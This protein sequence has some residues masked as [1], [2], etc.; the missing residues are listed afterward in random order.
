[1]FNKFQ[2]LRDEQ[3]DHGDAGGGAGDPLEKK[4][5]EQLD[6]MRKQREEIASKIS[7]IDGE[8]KKLSEDFAKATKDFE[9]LSSDVT[10]VITSMKALENKVAREQRA[11]YGSALDRITRDPELH[12]H[13][14]GILRGVAK[15]SCPN[16]TVKMNDDQVKAYEAHREAISKAGLDTG[17]SPGSNLVDDELN[18]QFYSLIAEYGVWNNFDVVP[19]STKTTKLITD[20][21]DPTMGFVSE[22]ASISEGSITG[23]TASVTAKKAAVYMGVSSEMLEDSEI[24]ITAFLLPKF[25]NAAAYRTDWTA[26]SAD[27]TDDA[28]DGAFTGLFHGG[29]ASALESGETTI[30]TADYQDFLDCMLAADATVLSRPTSRWILHPQMLVKILGLLDSNGRPIF[31]SAIDAP[32]LGAFGSILGFPVLLAHAA[33][34]TDSASNPVVAFGDTRGQAVLLRRAFEFA[35]SEHALFTSDK[36]AFRATT[37]IASKTRKATAFGVMTTAAS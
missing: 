16:R 3:G 20:D 1:M 11:A 23:T 29:T 35:A 19:A 34:N 17:N 37:R 22:G 25:A 10:K 2:I 14:E 26:L 28:T 8:G 33:P 27:G 30:A 32:S 31:Q 36:T 24:S 21:T 4:I 9:G 7:E 12:T 5:S 15:A 6:A 13:A 18:T